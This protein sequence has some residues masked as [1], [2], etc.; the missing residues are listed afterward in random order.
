MTKETKYMA[1]QII[2]EANY[3][4]IKWTYVDNGQISALVNDSPISMLLINNSIYRYSINDR[5]P[6]LFCR[7]E[8]IK[9][10]D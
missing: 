7:V 6:E 4:N 1:K 9:D 10:V 8:D 3:T 5:R 2:K